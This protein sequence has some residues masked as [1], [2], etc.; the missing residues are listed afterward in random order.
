[1]LSFIQKIFVWWRDATPGS[2]YDIHRRGHY[3][4]QDEFGN[5]YYEE[6]QESLEGRKRRWVIYKGYTD[7]SR[8]PADWHGWMH[9]IF[10]HPPTEQPFSLKPW[11]KDHQPNMTG[12]LH[13]YHP[14]G[15]LK[16]GGVR[17]PVTADYEAW[18]P[19]DRKN[20]LGTKA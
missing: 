14:R 16:H 9:H 12:S 7:A 3:V 4:G 2:L 11:E 5:K 19:E 8:I 18:T 1:M 13:A 10:E 6:R 15:A 20:K 17:S